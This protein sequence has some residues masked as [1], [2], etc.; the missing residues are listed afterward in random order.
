VTIGQYF[1][2]VELPDAN[3]GENVKLVFNSFD[4]STFTSGYDNFNGFDFNLLDV[5]I[6]SEECPG[7]Y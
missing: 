6:R 1:A 4:P 5:E 3:V 2:C 7:M